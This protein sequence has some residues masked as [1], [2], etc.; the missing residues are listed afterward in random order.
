MWYERN[1]YPS[2]EMIV[3]DLYEKGLLEAGEYEIDVD[4]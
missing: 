1:F 4:L 2:E 3:N